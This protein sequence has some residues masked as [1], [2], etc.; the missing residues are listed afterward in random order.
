VSDEP[1]NCTYCGARLVVVHVHGHGQCSHCGTNV[2]P[3]CSGA[4]PEDAESAAVCQEIAAD[5]RL[6]ERVFAHLGGTTASVSRESLC[7]ALG[8][9]LGLGMEEALIVLDAGVHTGKL[10]TSGP[11][12]YRLPH[13]A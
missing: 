12:T 10:R 6:F 5:P 8:Q 3:C 2:E 4:S 11:D 9:W 7:F 1:K 13:A